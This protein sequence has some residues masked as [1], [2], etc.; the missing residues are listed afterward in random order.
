MSVFNKIREWAHDRNL[1]KGST[2]EAQFEKLV[3]EAVI[4]LHKAIR[5][6]DKELFKDAIGDAGVVLTIMAAEEGLTFEECLDH[7]Y[8]EIK[9]RKGK[10]VDGVFVKEKPVQ[11]IEIG[12]DYHHKVH[13]RV[14][15]IAVHPH[16]GAYLMIEYTDKIGDPHFT[17]CEQSELTEKLPPVEF[18]LF[19]GR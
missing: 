11:F 1:I 4:E 6:K 13:G 16:D 8:N 5:L 18:P 10:M 19:E 17:G 9:D 7:A 14:T 15:L 3:E 2:P 12:A